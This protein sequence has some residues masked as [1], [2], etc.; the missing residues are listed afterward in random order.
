MSE[1]I[2]MR[3]DGETVKLL[4]ETGAAA[5]GSVFPF[6]FSAGSEYAAQLLLFHLRDRMQNSLHAIREEAY[7]EGWKAAKAHAK[8]QTWFAS[9]W[10]R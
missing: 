6:S 3:R 7:R 2:E 5:N 1:F 4:V 8:K 10:N 9:R